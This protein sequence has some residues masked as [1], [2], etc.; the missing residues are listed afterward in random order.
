MIESSVEWYDRRINQ[1]S[2]WKAEKQEAWRQQLECNNSHLVGSMVRF[3][4]KL[5]LRE[6]EQN[7]RRIL[8]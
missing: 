7:V 6:M 4:R 1:E 2:M 3:Y 8:S 5:R